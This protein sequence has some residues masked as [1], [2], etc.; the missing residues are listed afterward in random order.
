MLQVQRLLLHGTGEEQSKLDKQRILIVIHATN[1]LHPSHTPHA[2]ETHK[3]ALWLYSIGIVMLCHFK[4]LM[5][6]GHKSVL[7]C[8]KMSIPEEVK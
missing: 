5:S 2:E 8:Q 6:A 7:F 3:F 4:I 1:H